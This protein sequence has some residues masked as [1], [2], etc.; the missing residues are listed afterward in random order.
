MTT[1]S[2][3]LAGR[4]VT[5]EDVPDPV[6][7]DSLVGPGGAVDPARVPL[8]A[9]APL[10]GIV[11]SLQAHTFV[12]VDAAGRAVLTHLGIDTVQLAGEGF[13]PLVGKGDNV[14]RGQPLVRWDPAAVAASGRSPVCPV[15]ALEASAVDLTGL[16]TGRDVRAGDVLFSWN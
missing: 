13:E 4:V 10:D 3:P 5:L 11:V 15:I 1:V 2:S 6:F 8:E 14:R 16:R 7:A 9:L 12:V